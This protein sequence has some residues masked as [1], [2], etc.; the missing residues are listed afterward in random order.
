MVKETIRRH[1]FVAGE[2]I[3]DIHSNKVLVTDFQGTDTE[4]PTRACAFGGRAGLV[5]YMEQ[6][7]ESFSI[8]LF[9]FTS[10]NVGSV[11]FCYS[12]LKK[13]FFACMP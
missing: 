12:L 6:A 5:V 11:S 4:E 9:S 10:L 13:D 2:S 3:I 7:G 8:K 1:L